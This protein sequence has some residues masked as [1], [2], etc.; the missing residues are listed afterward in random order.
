MLLIKTYRSIVSSLFILLST[1]PCKNGSLEAMEAQEMI[2]CVEIGNTRIKASILPN[3]DLT[4]E[5][6]RKLNT[7]AFPSKPWLKQN[8]D[9]LFNKSSQTPLSELLSTNPVV[10]SL[11]I[12]GPIYDKRIHGCGIRNGLFENLQE[13]IQQQVSC[14][15]QIE[16]DAVSWA[17]GA[18]E[19][20]GLQSQTI[21]FP[22]VAI[23]FGTYIGVALIENPHKISALEIWAMSPAY[24][25]LT[26][27]AQ[28]YNLQDFPVA[29][30]LKKHID[31]VSGGEAFIEEKMKTYRPEFNQHVQA[32]IDDISEHLQM[33]FPCLP[34]IKSVLV[35]GG[36]SR[37]INTLNCSNRTSFI[38]SP[39]NLIA[40]GIAP[41]IIQ[42]LGCQKMCREDA[43]LTQTYPTLHEIQL[44]LEK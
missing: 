19:Y 39:H 25:R 12:F 44:V 15:I 34:K 2:L 23:T 13:V 8:V 9:Q 32:F 31:T 18:I 17:V 24:D 26:P 42:L 3:Y 16:S 10:I 21:D 36:Y 1:L 35:G 7:I 30:L 4:L 41:D 38:L 11:S 22:C 20:L 40:Q 33:I 5:D 37:F 27:F 29:I 14:P 6:L 28:S 43:I